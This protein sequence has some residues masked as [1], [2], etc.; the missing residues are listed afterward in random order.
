MH[1]LPMG[2]IIKIVQMYS[3]RFSRVSHAKAAIPNQAV[4][5]TICFDLRAVRRI[6]SFD[7][8]I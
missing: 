6:G 3:S 4:H 7:V 2:G 8:K 5:R 1:R